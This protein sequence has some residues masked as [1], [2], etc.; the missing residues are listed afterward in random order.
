MRINLRACLTQKIS[1]F[2]IE[3]DVCEQAEGEMLI[4][5]DGCEITAH[6]TSTQTYTHTTHTHTDTT[7]T[8]T[9][10]NTPLAH[11]QTP[12]PYAHTHTHTLTNAHTHKI[13]EGRSEI[14]VEF[15]KNYPLLFIVYR[16]SY[17]FL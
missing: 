4:C 9:H 13:S 6:T 11:T 15:W 8:H 2:S 5:T 17:C 7:T 1:T 14:L 16:Q 10:T 3:Q 12:L